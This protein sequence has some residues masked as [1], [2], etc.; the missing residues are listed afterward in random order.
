MK[1]QKQK[2]ASIIIRPPLGPDREHIS[3]ISEEEN[4][5]VKRQL[6][7]DYGY[8]LREYRLIN[9][10]LSCEY[11][12]SVGEPTWHCANPKSKKC[13]LNVSPYEV[14]SKWEPNLGLMMYL[15]HRYFNAEISRYRRADKNDRKNS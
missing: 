1:T 14:C 13:G 12:A 2:L 10:P 8:R 15:N 7:K 5:G 11:C 9:L 3:V 6:E 4:Q